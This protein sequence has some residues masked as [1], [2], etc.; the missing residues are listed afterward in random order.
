MLLLS[1]AECFV[2][3][4][5]APLTVLALLSDV[6]LAD[7]PVIPHNS[8]PDFTLLSLFVFQS[9]CTVVDNCL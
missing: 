4:K 6:K 2:F 9:N 1:M 8:C 3:N 7:R 5:Q